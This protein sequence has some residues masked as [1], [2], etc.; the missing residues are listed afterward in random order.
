LTRRSTPALGWRAAAL[1]LAALLS[2]VALP[3]RAE[4]SA[5]DREVVQQV[6]DYLNSVRSLSAEFVQIGPN[7]EIAKGQ[8]YLRR[9]GKLRFEYAP[10]SPLLL[11]ADGRW[12]VLEDKELQHVDRWPVGDTP[13]AVLV[14]DHVDLDGS[15]Q[16]TDVRREGGVVRITLIDRKRPGEGHLTLIFNETPL[17]LRQWEVHDAQGGVTHVSLNDTKVNVQLADKLFRYDHF[18]KFPGDQGR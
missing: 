5:Q 7:G 14:A 16:V 17:E 8:V 4:L 12:L 3:A 18:G 11:V 2:L 13:L 9:P 15:V 1:L 6:E 10:P